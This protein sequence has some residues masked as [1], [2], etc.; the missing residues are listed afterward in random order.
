MILQPSLFA[1]ADRPAKLSLADPPPCPDCGAELVRTSERWFACP[2]GHGG[3]TPA[4]R[5]RP[6]A[7]EKEER[8]AVTLFGRAWRAHLAYE[9]RAES[10]E[11]MRPVEPPKRC[12]HCDAV[13]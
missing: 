9:D 12:P 10:L 8:R 4:P 3:L 7:A 6:A 11:F 2:A 1:D 5:A 13:L